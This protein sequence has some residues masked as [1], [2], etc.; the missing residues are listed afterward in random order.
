MFL[1]WEQDPPDYLQLL[2][3]NY[4]QMM[5]EKNCPLSSLIKELS[6]VL[7]FS[8]GQSWIPER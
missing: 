2:N 1:L 5:Q 4:R 3:L 8:V 6:L 7:I